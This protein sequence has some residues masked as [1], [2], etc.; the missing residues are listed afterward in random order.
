MLFMSSFSL[1]KI[2]QSVV[3]SKYFEALSSAHAYSDSKVGRVVFVEQSILINQ[4]SSKH[5]FAVLKHGVGL[6]AL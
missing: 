6:S 4:S 2:L 5:S 1:S 3:V